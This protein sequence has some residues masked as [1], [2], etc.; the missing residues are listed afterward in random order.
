MDWNS[1]WAPLPISAM[2]RQLR[3]AMWRAARA[4]MAAVRNAVVSVSS[5]SRIG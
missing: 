4:D 3:R 1:A 5:D 2:V